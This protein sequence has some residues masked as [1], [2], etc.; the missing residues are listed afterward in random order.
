MIDRLSGRVALL[1]VVVA[2]AAVVLLGWFVLLSPE[3]AKA[4]KLD[5]QIGDT[6]T[7]LAAVTSL[8]QGPT[9]RQSLISH[10]LFQKAVPDDPKVSQILRQLSVA[11]AQSGVE[12]DG[13]TPTALVPGAGS[14]TLP[15][16]LTVKGHYFAL[17][18]FLRILRNEADVHNGQVRSSGRL[19]TV[20]SIQFTGGAPSSTPGA[21]G[22]NGVIQAALALD[23]YVYSPSS[24]AAATATPVTPGDTTT[25]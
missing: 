15:I 1:L 24:V 20:D 3:K 11:A 18:A 19:F 5:V 21:V 22:D 6:N 16:S 13:I 17:Q 4:D 14:E 2:A 8:L 7:Q 10:R 23:A 25:P 12:L 9:G